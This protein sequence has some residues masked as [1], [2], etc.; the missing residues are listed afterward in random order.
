[1]SLIKEMYEDIKTIYYNNLRIEEQNSDIYEKNTITYYKNINLAVATANINMNYVQ[2]DTLVYVV[3][4]PDLERLQY[5]TEDLLEVKYSD[6]YYASS[7]I[8]KLKGNILSIQ[9]YQGLC[10]R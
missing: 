5:L 6:Q 9:F 10:Y 2:E 1:M 4:N 3:Y 7:N 8:G